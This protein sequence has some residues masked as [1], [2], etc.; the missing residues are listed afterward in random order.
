M[1]KKQFAA[2]IARK[3]IRMKVGGFRPT[4]NPLASW[5]GKVLV[6]RAD[7]QW[8]AYHGKPMIPL[9]QVNLNDFPFK[10]ENLADIA[11]IT[12][13]IDGEN[14]PGDED[15]NGT[16]WCL[17]TCKSLEGLVP[18]AP[19]ET[20]SSIKPMQMLPEVVHQDFPYCEN[21]PVKIP[22]KYEANYHELFHNAQGVKFGGRPT[23]IQGEVFWAP[24]QDSV[25]GPAFAF[26][27]DSVEKARW[28]W[29][30]YGVA[31]FGGGTEAG[32]EDAWTF[33][34]QCF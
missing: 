1:D 4:H 14:I 30:N 5:F 26:Q 16:S 29:G 19:V 18:L 12:L 9:C 32:K 33:A 22:D 24:P 13:F 6:A 15:P 27:I 21:C 3:A 28:Q 34:W 7:E 17:R 2:E 23:L 25:V 31:Y 20:N 10:P 11:F 8:P